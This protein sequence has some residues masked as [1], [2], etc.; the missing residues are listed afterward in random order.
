MPLREKGFTR[1]NVLCL[2][3]SRLCGLEPLYAVVVC[4][5]WGSLVS[6]HT[7][8][9]VDRTSLARF[10]RAVGLSPTTFF[11]ANLVVHAG[12]CL[13]SLIRPPVALHPSHGL[14]AAA[15]HAW[16]GALVSQGTM[17]LDDVY[18]AMP[19]DAWWRMWVVCVAVECATPLVL[20]RL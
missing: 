3:V 20:A 12:P 8:L 18:V 11:V 10:A 9:L 16:W 1:W 17:R 6:F 13:F 7:S 5:S 19:A 14:V 4:T 2:L 15:V